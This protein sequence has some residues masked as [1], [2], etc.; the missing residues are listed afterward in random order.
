MLNPDIHMPQSLTLK[1][2]SSAP[3]FHTAMES[4]DDGDGI[5]NGDGANDGRGRPNVDIDI[6]VVKDSL[7]DILKGVPAFRAIIATEAT[8][9]PPAREPPA[10][11]GG[12][13]AGT[14][15]S[16]GAVNPGTS[17]TPSRG[18]G[19]TSKVKAITSVVQRA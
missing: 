12:G 6:E 11:G 4:G 5:Y 7:M 19:G 2:E 10:T 3:Q 18:T 16:A 13:G 14:S 17:S 9:P 1:Q 15:G 8:T